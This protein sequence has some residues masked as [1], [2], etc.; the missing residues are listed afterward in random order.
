MNRPVRT[1]M[2]QQAMSLIGI[3]KTLFPQTIENFDTFG[4]KDLK[5]VKE[6][7]INYLSS[8]DR[9]FEENKGLFL[10]GSNGVGKTFIA[11]MIVK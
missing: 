8:L 11:S 9:A 5:A 2:S 1:K 3:P 7:V 10:Y 6:Y 4:S